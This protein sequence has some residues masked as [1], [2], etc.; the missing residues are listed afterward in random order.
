M[1]IAYVGLGSN[2]DDREGYL[3]AALREIASRPEVSVGPVS[4]FHETAPA[5]GPPQ[6]NYL[7]AVARL[8][9]ELPPMELLRELQR[10]EAG[11][12]R[13]RGIRW[14]P[15]TA[16]LD[17]LTY[18]DAVIDTDE[19]RVPHPLM[20]GRLFVLEPLAEIAP[21]LAHPLFGKTI[22]Q[23]LDELRRRLARGPSSAPCHIAIAGP[24][25]AGK[26]TLALLLAA[27]VQLVPVLEQARN[28]PLLGPFYADRKK[29]ALSTQ[30]W[31]LLE[32]ASQLR[33]TA[34]F[35]PRRFVSDYIF[36]KDR[37][38]AKLNLGGIELETYN[39][40][41][42]LV[43]T[44]LPQPDVIIYLR[45]APEHL[46]RRVELRGRPYE[47]H[48]R[49]EYMNM[50]SEEYDLL[51]SRPAGAPVIRIQSDDIA[52]DFVRGGAAFGD[53]LRQVADTLPQE[54]WCVDE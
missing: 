49:A 36:D 42:A 31:F 38:F 18:D 1:A 8:E 7:N 16:D 39:I 50:L 22:T 28:N 14:G 40:A 34:Q 37:I 48:M 29:H 13:R 5:G 47:S 15:R 21:Q 35:R 45:A 41:R 30:L 6:G 4:S 27:Q 33:E 44:P 24:I 11:M 2:L 32:R 46:M 54:N 52:E 23:L 25:A 12:S 51:F 43:G 19:L 20:H 17:I 3:R 9:T 26:T 53:L 10:I